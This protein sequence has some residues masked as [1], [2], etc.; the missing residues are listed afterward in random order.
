MLIG[1]DRSPLRPTAALKPSR[2]LIRPHPRAGHH[3]QRGT[4]D[5]VAEEGDAIPR[6]LLLLLPLVL[7]RRREHDPVHGAPQQPVGPVAEQIADVDED[8]RAGVG[9]RAGR[10][11][12]DGR[13]CCGRRRGIVDDDAGGGVG[14]EFESRLAAQA[15]QQRDGA[16]VGVGAGADVGFVGREGVGGE[17]G[18]RRV[19]EEAQDVARGPVLAQVAGVEEVW[20]VDGEA[21]AEEVVE[22][23]G[24]AVAVVVWVVG[25]VCG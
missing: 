11:H 15:E 5:G 21:E 16:V 25:L 19:V 9:F 22:L 24:E 6:L 10:G 18:A 14:V 7:L 4:P 17:G 23:E 12:R 3:L 8:G 13:P 1:S 20:G 2:R